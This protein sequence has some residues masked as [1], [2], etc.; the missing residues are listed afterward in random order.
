MTSYNGYPNYQGFQPSYYPSQQ[1]PMLRGR[2]ATSV[3]EVRASSIIMD[4]LE[5]YFPLPAENAIYTKSID[6]NGNAVI[7]K[8]IQA[9]DEPSQE[10]LMQTVLTDLQTRVKSLEELIEGAVK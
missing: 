6:M 3:D 1:Q 8:Y 9:Q 2:L 4:G 7:K 10:K 5:T